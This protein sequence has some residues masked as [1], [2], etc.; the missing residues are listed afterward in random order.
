MKPT[1]LLLPDLEDPLPR[2]CT[3]EQEQRENMIELIGLEMYGWLT[4]MEDEHAGT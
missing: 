4:Q 1:H 2:P 3:V